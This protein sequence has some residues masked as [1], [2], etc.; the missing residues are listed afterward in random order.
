MPKI[1]R[2][3]FLKMTA[4]TAAAGMINFPFIAHGAKKQVI[5]VG[6]GA[7]GATAAKYIA[8]T[9][10][11]IE[12]TLIEQ[13]KNY[14]TCFM[15]NE[16]LAGK[17]SLDSLKFGYDNLAKYGINVVHD[18][19]TDIDAIAKTVTTQNGKTFIY[20]RLVVAPG[21][22]FKWE[23][24]DGY[25]EKVA[26]KIPHA[27]QFG[28]QMTGLRNQLNAMKDG[29]QVIIAV[30]PK[31]YR[32]PPGPYERAS[33]I[34]HYLKHHKPKSKILIFDA[35]QAFSKQDLFTQGWE[36]LYGFGTDNSLIDWIP[37]DKGGT[38]SGVDANNM[39]VV[40][41]EFE[42]KHQAD[43]INLIPPQKAGKIAVDAG[44]TN[45]SGWCPVNPKTFESTLQKHIHVIGDASMIS[46]M[47]K[48]GY[49][50]NSQAKICAMAVVAALQG[51]EMGKPS[52]VNTCYS[53]ISENYAVSVATVYRLEGDKIVSVKGS[54][55][56]SPMD[57]TA[58]DRKREALYAHSWF[59]NITH[60]IFG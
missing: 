16:V 58:E 47:P 38:V 26:K 45:E 55:G 19:V 15:S 3:N 9:D 60:D 39:T 11:S 28:H 8:Q 41:G 44:L 37:A 32:C 33:L 12:V 1:T 40:A 6:G 23:A 48:S 10:S 43:V 31:P 4:G 50:A 2:R 7:G 34:A 20:D 14:Y 36:K 24:I 13:H 42:D 21:I 18:H 57:A 49:A 17:R 56:F 25:D 59:K 30:P 54:G 5:V 46:P 22:D 35:N 53:M 52:Y 27:W 29:G 51:V